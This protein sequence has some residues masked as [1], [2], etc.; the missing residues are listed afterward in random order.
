MLQH[1]VS[2]GFVRK[3]GRNYYMILT[4]DGQRKQCKT[5]TNDADKA[6]EMLIE[7]RTQERAGI[8]ADTRL[9]YEDLR[10]AYIKVGG[11]KPQESILRDLDTF[12][13]NLSVTAITVTKITQFRAWRESLSRVAEYKQE[14]IEKPSVPTSLRQF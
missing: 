9:R 2:Q 1:E 3:V 14:T 4:V 6:M 5:G 7:W 8:Q 11:K 10:D 12:F 13:K